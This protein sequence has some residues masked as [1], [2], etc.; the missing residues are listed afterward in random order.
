[1]NVPDKLEFGHEKVRQAL[2]YDEVRYQ[3]NPGEPHVSPKLV[4]FS[5]CKNHIRYMIKYQNVS[6]TDPSKIQSQNHN[7]R[8]DDRWKDF[9]DLVR[10]AVTFI[11]AFPYESLKP[12]L[13]KNFRGEYR[14]L[15][16]E[17]EQVPFKGV[18]T[19]V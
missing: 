17:R 19:R 9:P 10:Y 4:F 12:K 13:K 15:D 16:K 14:K 11:S 2:W 5:N 18:K 1:V 6:P 3:E 7:E 8:V